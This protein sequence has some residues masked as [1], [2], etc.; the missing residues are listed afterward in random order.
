MMRPRSLSRCPGADTSRFL[1]Q[2]DKTAQRRLGI[3][4]FPLC[5][6]YRVRVRLVIVFLKSRLFPSLPARWWRLRPRRPPE[7]ALLADC[8][9]QRHPVHRRP[10]QHPDQSRQ[11]QPASAQLGRPGGDQLPA[12]PGALSLQPGASKSRFAAAQRCG[13]SAC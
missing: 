11:P 10:G 9:P 12:G 4:I 5:P 3:L 7:G 6:R 1:N 13:H 8:G 2:S